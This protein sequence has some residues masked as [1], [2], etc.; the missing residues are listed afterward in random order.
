MAGLGLEPVAA[1]WKAQT[2]SLSY[3]GT[4]IIGKSQFL[5]LKT[6]SHKNLLI[7]KHSWCAPRLH[8]NRNPN[9]RIERILESCCSGLPKTLESLNPDSW[10]R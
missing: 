9:L 7:L 5:S 6:L 8:F 4:H 10:D 3:G 2:N 1:E